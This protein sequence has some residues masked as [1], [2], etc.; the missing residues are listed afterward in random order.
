MGDCSPASARFIP[1]GAGN[2]S[3]MASQTRCSTVHPRWRGEHVLKHGLT[4]P[5]RGSSPL[6]RGT[7]ADQH[8]P[9]AAR[10]F[11]PAGAGNTSNS[12]SITATATVHPRWR[13]EHTMAPGPIERSGGSS[14]LARGTHFYLDVA[15]DDQRFIPAGAGNTSSSSR[16][17]AQ[18]IGSSPL[19]RGTRATWSPAAWR[20]RFIPAGAG[21]TPQPG[22]WPPVR[23]VHPRWRGE[24]G[25]ERLEQGGVG[26]SSPLARGTRVE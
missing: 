14:P 7:R 2:T 22:R 17:R 25:L 15:V 18:A 13:G 1:A 10:R 16:V 6:A 21:N 11:I 5:D 3:Q 23:P 26:G 9:A 20:Y 8:R 19:A 4:M 12:H 24:H